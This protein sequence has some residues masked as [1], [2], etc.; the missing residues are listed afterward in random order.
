MKSLLHNIF[1]LGKIPR[2]ILP[3]IKEE[4]ILLSEEG[5]SGSVTLSNFR[6]PGRRH[7]K[8]CSWI[9]GSIALT[10]KRLWVFQFSNPFISVEWNEPLIN[11][12]DCST[13]DKGD[14]IF[15]FDISVFDDRSS[16]EVYC[17]LKSSKSFE[18]LDEIRKRCIS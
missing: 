16:G 10:N 9:M 13:N 8:K 6:A 4:G 11:K 14:L 12:I 17:K 1:G 3:T 2:K 5:I 18:I 7:S 15:S